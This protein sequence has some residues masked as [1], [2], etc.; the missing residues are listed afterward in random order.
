MQVTYL[1]RWRLHLYDATQLT[2]T[3]ELEK[4]INL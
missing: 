1:N 3:G 2:T 4:E